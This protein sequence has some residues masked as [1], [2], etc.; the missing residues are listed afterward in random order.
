V[1]T[2]QSSSN[3]KIALVRA[4][5]KIPGGSNTADIG[6]KASKFKGTYEFD[7]VNLKGADIGQSVD[8]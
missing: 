8:I 1:V 3:A 2:L 4:V 7:D 5:V 6:I